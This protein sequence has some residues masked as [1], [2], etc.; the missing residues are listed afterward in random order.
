MIKKRLLAGAA[1]A[2]LACLTLAA[3]AAA[4]PTAV[5]PAAEVAERRRPSIA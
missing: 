1:T 4:G 3:C 5:A 2:T